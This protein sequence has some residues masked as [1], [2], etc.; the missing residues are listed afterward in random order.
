MI[1]CW[2]EFSNFTSLDQFKPYVNIMEML[3]NTQTKL[4]S[5]KI[6]YLKFYINYH[7]QDFL[8]LAI[9]KEV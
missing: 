8:I 3:R 2:Y 6:T 5:T 9:S 7:E 4:Q 1:A